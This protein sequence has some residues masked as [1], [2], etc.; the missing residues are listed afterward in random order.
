VQKTQ[1]AEDAEDVVATVTDA[2]AVV[3]PAD[4][5]G[6]VDTT[7]VLDQA[8]PPAADAAE[9]GEDSSSA[10]AFIHQNT[11]IQGTTKIICFIGAAILAVSTIRSMRA[12]W[13]R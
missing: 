13:R 4:E 11:T 2:A 8:G 6:V 9:A 1:A 12:S 5:T 7:A 3:D 10:W